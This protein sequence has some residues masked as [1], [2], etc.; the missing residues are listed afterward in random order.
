MIDR[1]DHVVITT[2]QPDACIAFYTGV[3]GMKLEHFGEGR[4]AFSFGKQKINL[5]VKGSEYEPK[6]HLPVSG[7]VDI[8]F[9]ADRP[10][11]QVIERLAAANVKIIQGPVPK[12]GAIGKLRSVYVRDPDLNLIEISEYV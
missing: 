4:R 10:L 2:T 6:A 7:S 8:C 1:I 3:M 11:D 12:T 9:I 5:H